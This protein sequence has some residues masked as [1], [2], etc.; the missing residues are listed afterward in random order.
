MN[1]LQYNVLEDESLLNLSERNKGENEKIIG[2]NN[3]PFK[4]DAS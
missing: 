4:K 1:E 2:T 3:Q